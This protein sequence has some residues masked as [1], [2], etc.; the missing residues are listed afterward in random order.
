M[1][2]ATG[3]RSFDELGTPLIDTTFCVLDIETTGS[4]TEHD[5]ITE[6][7]A[8]K[9]R[10]GE[11]LGTFQTLV[12]PGCAVPPEITVLT[13]IT[14]SMVRKA[15]RIESVLPAFSR[16]VEGCVVVGHNVRFDLSFLNLALG[17]DAWPQLDG[18]AVDTL[19]LARRLLRDDVPNCK[20]STL[21]SRLR[22]DHRPSHRALDDALA[23]ADLFHALLERAA[24]FGVTGL[25]DLLQLPRMNGHPQAAKLKMTND[26]PRSPG[27]YLF[28]DGRGEVLYVGKAAN[29]RQRVRSYFSG[30]DRRKVG[31][32]LRET[33]HI[34]HIVCFSGLDAAVLEV[35]LIHRHQPRYNRQAKLWRKYVY[36]KLTTN[37]RFP[38]LT[39]TKTAHQ[40]DG[41]YLGPLTSNGIARLVIEAIETAVPLRRCSGRLGHKL[42]RETPCT[43]AQLGVASCPCAGTIGEAA[44]RAHVERVIRGLTA[45]PELLLEP[46]RERMVALASTERFEE[47]GDV[48]NRADALARA[49][50]RQRRLTALRQ[51]GRLH[52]RLPGGVDAHL[53]HGRLH[54]V[55]PGGE[56]QL[57]FDEPDDGPVALDPNTPLPREL[58]DEIDCIARYFERYANKLQLVSCEG[59]LAH[60]A[61]RAPSF[62][63][64]VA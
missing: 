8:V 10:A 32:L 54:S 17:R 2:P 3:Q 33:R 23:T 57:S 40:G 9:V 7:G 51:A 25:D 31:G 4:S 60:P 37:E 62:A 16:F 48:R 52:L 26:L 55:I 63:P 12:N 59:L 45:E 36:V 15:P 19:P 35:R 30:D 47:A 11:C 20:L 5:S 49:I 24:A 43:P 56:G 6:I 28:R 21:A 1:P 41:F 64:R 44:Y 53:S 18:P 22:L 39:I 42:T 13:G 58:A 61:R 27:V 34:D 29:L 38:R 50:E 46:L 14:E